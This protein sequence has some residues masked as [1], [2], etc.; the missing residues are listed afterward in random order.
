MADARC[1]GC[2]ATINAI[3]AAWLLRKGLPLLCLVCRRP[4]LGRDADLE[5]DLLR[6]AQ[7]EEVT[8]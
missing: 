2:P 6:E 4:D 5:H 7:G 1:T 8:P 3:E